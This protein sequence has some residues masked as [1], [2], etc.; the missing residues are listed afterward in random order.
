MILKEFFYLRKSD[1]KVIL[2]LLC[3][4]AIALGV[5]IFTGNNNDASNA[6]TPADS[7]QSDSVQKHAYARSRYHRVDTI[8]MKPRYYRYPK[9]A[10]RDSARKGHLTVARDSMPVYQAR[11]KIAE[12]EHVVLNTADTTAL[13]TVPGVG[14]Y[15]ARRIVQ[16]GERLGG[17][18][19]VAQLDEIG[20]L[21][22]EVKPYLTV[23]NPSPRRLNVNKLSLEQLRRHPYINFYQAKAIVDYRRLHGPI[24][25]LYD[26]RLSKD[27][28]QTEIDRLL[29]YV[30]Y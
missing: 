23:E 8:Y 13:M 29:P 28:P 1:R 19:S 27:F 11:H 20:D 4:I 22:D 30:E 6:L 7:L 15:Y 16:Y 9:Y 14:P 5:I 12:G 17:Y 18:V 25:S 21:P 26:L 2:T 3:V 10:R 24:K